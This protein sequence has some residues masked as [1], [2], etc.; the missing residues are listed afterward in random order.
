MRLGDQLQLHPLELM[1]A[2]VAELLA[3]GGE[4]FEG[5]RVTDASHRKDKVT[6]TTEQAE[7]TAQHVVLATSQPILRRHGYFARLHPQRSYAA[8]LRSPRVPKGMYLSADTPSRSV[9]SHPVDGEELLLVGGNGHITGRAAS[10]AAKVEDLVRWALDQFGGEV[11]HA[12][13][14][15]DHESVTALPYVGPMSPGNQAVWVATGFDKWGFAAAPAAAL[16]LTKS[17]LA[18]DGAGERPPWHRAFS[19]WTPR[20][21]PGQARRRCS[22]AASASR[23]QGRPASA[24][25]RGR[26]GEPAV[27]RDLHPPRR[28]RAL[29]RRG[30]VLGLPAA[31]I[32]VRRR[33]IGPRRAGCV[34]PQEAL[35][36]RRDRGLAR[37]GILE[38]RYVAVTWSVGSAGSSVVG[39]AWRGGADDGE[40]G[41]GS[42]AACSVGPRSP[43][44]SPS[45]AGRIR[46][47]LRGCFAVRSST[48][49]SRS[50]DRDHPVG[51]LAA[52]GG[53]AERS[54][55]D[56]SA[57]SRVA[58]SV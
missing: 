48:A 2:L 17:I 57:S 45:R 44:S 25:A 40:S 7:V 47:N 36:R 34:R 20:R 41:P 12:W 50:L 19:S 23:L 18:E 55:R 11:T 24:V 21:P 51:R 33:R 30:T 35:E 13:L 49:T 52:L 27:A 8:A 10:E 53:V 4:L 37:S 42:G 31:R 58:P 26:G 39:A 16:L 3:E 43:S 15:Q 22:T 9:R 6:V 32:A 38:R 29:E 56:R 14:A 5:T 1:D 28:R 46:A 54:D